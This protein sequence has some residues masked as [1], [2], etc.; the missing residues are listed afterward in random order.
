YSSRSN[1]AALLQVFQ[2]GYGNVNAGIKTSFF[3]PIA[4]F[5]GGQSVFG[6]LKGFYSRV[7]E[8]A[9]NPL[10][11]DDPHPSVIIV[12]QHGGSLTGTGKSAG[13]SNMNDFVIVFQKFVPEPGYGFH[14]R[15]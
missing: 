8:C 2:S 1:A 15:L 4:D 3:Q 10:V 9:G 6:L 5:S 7:T 14:G 11:V 13:H 12:R